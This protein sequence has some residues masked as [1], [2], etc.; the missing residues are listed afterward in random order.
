MFN[1]HSLADAT[2]Y[3]WRCV[4]RDSGLPVCGADPGREPQPRLRGAEGPGH[5]E[6]EEAPERAAL[7]PGAGPALVAG[8]EAPHLPLRLG[9]QSSVCCL[10]RHWTPSVASHGESVQLSLSLV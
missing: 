2:L 3:C 9:G 6:E 8:H 4:G 7:R 10:T 1:R 5:G